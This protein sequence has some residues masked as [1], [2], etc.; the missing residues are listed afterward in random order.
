M[1]YKIYTTVC[2]IID[3]IYNDNKEEYKKFYIK[4]IPK[5]MKSIHG[6]YTW[7]RR[8]IEIFNLS[9]PYNHIITT[10]LHE[11]AH[12]IDYVIRG[13]TDH[14]KEFYD[15]FYRLII[16]ALELSIISKNDIITETDS[17]DKDRLEKHFG[18]IRNWE[19]NKSDYKKDI[20]II[21][22]SNSYQ[23]KNYLK[24]KGYKYSKLEQVWF[25][26]VKIGII[27]EEIEILKRLTDVE[28]IKIIYRNDLEIEAIY[29]IVV[30]NSYSHRDILKKSGY[31]YNGYGIQKKSW[32]KKIK[33]NELENE[34]EL[35]N[36][37][38]GIKFKII[39]KKNKRYII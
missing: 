26:E 38:D 17:A 34:K 23:L 29:Y 3:Y 4:I 14:K 33:A 20:I 37:L 30:L 21:K 7:N 6:R 31:I 5:E 2:D 27:S 15:I 10:I 8:L 13:L 19:V 24:M 9:R 32:N 12:H 36:K 16:G 18:S 22:V 35:L 28:N 1:E 25:K 11:V 39:N